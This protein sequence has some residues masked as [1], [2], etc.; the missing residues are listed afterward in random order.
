ME[1]PIA[2]RL[3]TDPIDQVAVSTCNLGYDYKT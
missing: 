2:A 1:A 3:C